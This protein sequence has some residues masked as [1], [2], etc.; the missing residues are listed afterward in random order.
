MANQEMID[1][2]QPSQKS[3]E[4]A[5]L[6][7]ILLGKIWGCGTLYRY[8][9][10]F[11]SFRMMLLRIFGATLQTR[12]KGYVS[13]SPKARIEG[14]WNIEIGNLSSIGNKAWV[15]ALDRITVGSKTCIGE[16]VKLL[17]GYHDIT[18]KN[19]A[20]KRK[21]ITIGSCVWIATG[22]IVLPGVAIGDGAVVAAGA[23]VTKDVQPWTVVGGNPAKFI[24]KRVLKEN[25]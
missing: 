1:A 23:V 6:K 14:P 17:T 7:T 15:Y 20:F 16:H 19:F 10:R 24:K 11:N 8:S 12:P 3:L 13:I 18:T 22:A 5:S 2:Y 25:S 21:P 9:W 4:R